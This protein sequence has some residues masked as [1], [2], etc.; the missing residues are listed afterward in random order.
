MYS[1]DESVGTAM[2]GV[3]LSNQSGQLTENLVFTFSTVDNSA[4]G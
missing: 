4:T 3:R 2:L 1:F